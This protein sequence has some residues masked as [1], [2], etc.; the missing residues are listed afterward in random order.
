VTQEKDFIM[1]FKKLVGKHC[2]ILAICATILIGCA[3]PVSSSV[4]TVNGTPTIVPLSLGQFPSDKSSYHIYVDFWNGSTFISEKDLDLSSTSGLTFSNFSLPVGTTRFGIYLLDPQ[5]LNSNPL[6]FDFYAVKS[7]D[8]SYG[9]YYWLDYTGYFNTSPKYIRFGISEQAGSTISSLS[10]L[11]LDFNKAPYFL[12]NY[13]NSE[14][15]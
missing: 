4:S 9:S 8:R 1:H 12:F 5:F 11:N 7:G 3:S 15:V 14:V 10:A 6:Y 13:P 2:C